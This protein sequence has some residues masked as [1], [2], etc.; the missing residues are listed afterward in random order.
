VSASDL[1]FETKV[2]EAILSYPDAVD[3]ASVSPKAS[4]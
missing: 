4:A 3:P 2:A 1:A